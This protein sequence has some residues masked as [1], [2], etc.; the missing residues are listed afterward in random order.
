MCSSDLGGN[1]FCFN[2]SCYCRPG[3]TG[4]D[5]SLKA[6]PNECSNHG[7]CGENDS[8]TCHANW[9]GSDCSLRQC[10]S[11]KSWITTGKGDLNYD[12]D[13]NDATIYQPDTDF[14]ATS[15]PYIKTQSNSG[16]DW[17]N[18]PSKFSDTGEAHFYMECSNR[19]TCNR[20]TGECECFSGY[21]GEACRRTEC[22]DDCN[23]RGTC[24]NQVH[25]YTCT[26]DPGFAGKDCQTNINDCD[27][28]LVDRA[29]EKCAN[30]GVCVDGNNTYSCDCQPGFT[31]ELC[32]GL[33]DCPANS[34][35]TVGGT[36][37]TG[38]VIAFSQ[39][40]HLPILLVVI[41]V[42]FGLE[43]LKQCARSVRS[44]F[45]LQS[46]DHAVAAAIHVFELLRRAERQIGRASCRE[47]V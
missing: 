33:V 24:I 7:V 23:G 18:W 34:D 20:D 22:P 44:E 37:G 19:G 36:G 29:G 5:C 6:C 42:V 4:M 31:G 30:G 40:L 28:A 32:K 43:Y 11:Y 14:T 47:R 9:I 41:D 21:T 39:Q 1:G 27:A 2:G 45:L 26:C 16:G 25:A 8:C 15:L 17:E 35:G 3:F 12:G 13:T 46:H 38:A 10:M